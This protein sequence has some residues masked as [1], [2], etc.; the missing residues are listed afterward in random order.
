[1]QQNINLTSVWRM[2]LVKFVLWYFYFIWGSWNETRCSQCFQRAG[3]KSC[4]QQWQ[5]KMAALVAASA[6]YTVSG[7]L[8]WKMGELAR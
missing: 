4:Q 6:L 1:M 5:R 8:S 7:D 3:G 2:Q